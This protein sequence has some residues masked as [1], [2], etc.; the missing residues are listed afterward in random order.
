[1]AARVK[2][3]DN[4][5]KTAIASLVLVLSLSVAVL[6]TGCSGDLGSARAYV[7]KGDETIVVIERNSRSLGS[8]IEKTFTGLYNEISAGKTPSPAPF[9]ASAREMKSLADGML[10]DAA[11]ARRQ[12]AKVRDLKGVPYYRKYADLKIKVIDANVEGLK[13]LETFLDETQKK[14]SA[15]PFDPVAFQL[16][17]NQFSSSLQKKGEE[18][19]KLQKQAEDLKKQKQL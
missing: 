18:T 11:E 13:Q 19:G 14:L 12:F 4:M 17:V 5:R 1:M 9:V 8:S 7:K 10:S 3:A 16:Y 6:V 2:H 15:S